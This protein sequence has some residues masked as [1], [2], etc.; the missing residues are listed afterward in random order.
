[1]TFQYSDDLTQAFITNC[2]LLSL[3]ALSATRGSAGAPSSLL[4]IL[5]SASNMSI[6]MALVSSALH[7]YSTSTVQSI[8]LNSFWEK[9]LIVPLDKAP[10]GMIMFL[11]ST[12]TSVVL[13][14][15]TSLTVP[16]KPCASMK[17]PALKGRK[18]RIMIPPAKFWTVP[19]SAI[20]IAIPPPASKA[21]NDV[22]STPRAPTVTMIRIIVSA[23]LT[24]L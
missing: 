4:R 3:R 18:T 7:P 9:L 6:S 17:S 12:V 15:V 8:L 10:L 16:E 5:L 22:V 24:M 21:A 11:L 23:M 20:P 13:T 1:M 2:T 19:F 14:M